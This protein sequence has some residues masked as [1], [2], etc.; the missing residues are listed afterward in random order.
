MEGRTTRPQGTCRA[1]GLRMMRVT[2]S[3]SPWRLGGLS[4]TALARRV[5]REAW[6]DEVTIR[7]AALSYYWLFSLFPALLF[8]VALV[9]YLPLTGLQQRLTAYITTVLPPDAAATVTRT[10]DEVLRGNRGDLLSIGVLLALWAG[11]NGMASVISTLNIAYDVDESRAWWRR[12]ALAIVLTVA[13]SLFIVATLAL[14]VF[15]PKIGAAVAGW[16]GLSRL[17]TAAWNVVSVPIVI[18]CALVGVGLVYHLAPN[19]R[20]RG[21]WITPGAVLTVVLWLTMSWG[22]RLYVAHFANYNATYGLDRRR[23]FAHAVAVPD[24]RGA[25][26]RGRG[27]RR[28]RARG[29]AARR[30]HGGRRA[31]DTRGR[32]TA[33]T[34]AA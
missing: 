4:V 23:D 10:L 14:L 16:F 22:L 5:W 15:G 13:F 3:E 20:E 11:S 34:A 28:D 31:G 29:P 24:Q 8:L 17:F 6:D 18:A 30:H 12:R 26:D 19:T 21:R 2:S 25:T 1:L 7:A 33:V 32:V 9:G 27:R